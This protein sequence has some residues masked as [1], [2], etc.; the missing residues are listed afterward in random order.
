MEPEWDDFD[1]LNLPL[2]ENILFCSQAVYI[3][4]HLE[5]KSYISQTGVTGLS[6]LSTLPSISFSKSFPIDFMHLYYINIIPAMF[7]HF[8]GQ[9]FH[10]KIETSSPDTQ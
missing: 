10:S 9:Y 2:C 8:H 5:N 1:P 6:I 4:R 3:Q 7:N